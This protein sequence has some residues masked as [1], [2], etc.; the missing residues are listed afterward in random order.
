MRRNV[1]RRTAL[2]DAAI[3]V[4]AREGARGLTFRAVDA[5]A[6]VPTGTASNYFADRDDLLMQAGRRVYDRLRPDEATLAGR[7]E[8]PRDLGQGHRAAARHGR[9]HHRLPHRLP[10]PPGTA[11]GGDAAARAAR[12]PDRA[13]ARGRG[14]QHR[15]PPRL[16]PAGRRRLGPPPLPRAQL[17]DRGSTS[18][19]R[20]SSPRRRSGTW[21]RSRWS[22]SSRTSRR[23][24]GRQVSGR[25]GPFLICSMNSRANARWP[26]AVGW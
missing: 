19:C 8:G 24:A 3:E 16:G 17:A 2:V 22:A 11:P 21:W 25:P 18:P 7:M 6:G 1:E 4:L 26:A 12:P 10:R 20:A 5:E 23:G 14:G 9:A 13:R 15:R